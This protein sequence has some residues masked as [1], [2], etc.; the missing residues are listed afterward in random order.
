PDL[1]LVTARSVARA[2]V[3]RRSIH[4]RNVMTRAP[5]HG[6]STNSIRVAH[7]ATV[8]LTLRFLLLPQLESLRAEGYDVTAISAPGPW[9]EH[10]EARGIRHVA[11]PHATRSWDPRSDA[12]AFAE[13]L[14][15]FRDHRFH[16][17]HTH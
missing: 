1:H 8:D 15:I 3:T 7:V 2:P 16:L 12:R 17:V 13:L 11:W 4:E 6:G 9:V 14:A 5:R 10:L